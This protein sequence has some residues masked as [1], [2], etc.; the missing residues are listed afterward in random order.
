MEKEDSY[1]NTF[2][3]NYDEAL[4]KLVKSLLEDGVIINVSNL[5]YG[6][7]NNESKSFMFMKV[8]NAVAK[9]N[10]DFY[11]NLTIKSIEELMETIA[12]KEYYNYKIIINNFPVVLEFEKNINEAIKLVIDN[13]YEKEIESIFVDNI[14]SSYS[15]E[16]I[17]ILIVSLLTKDSSLSSNELMILSRLLN[18]NI[19]Y[20]KGYHSNDSS[21]ELLE[22]GF[23]INDLLGENVDIFKILEKQTIL[24]K[25]FSSKELSDNILGNIEAIYSLEKR[26]RLRSKE[27]LKDIYIVVLMDKL[28]DKSR[29]QNVSDLEYGQMLYIAENK[30]S[31]QLN[32]E[33]KDKLSVLRK[34]IL[35]IKL[36][37]KNLF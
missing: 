12:E 19:D 15:I 14:Q 22:K 30:F 10:K 16:L 17:S 29:N 24:N 3:F 7:N 28:F 37:I 25:K 34:N 2:Y 9:L 21:K 33:M 13:N 1:Y 27:S 31:Y 20:S 11:K 35:G 5:N 4:E 6:F 18:S 36:L 8:F 23:T 26:S 32:Q